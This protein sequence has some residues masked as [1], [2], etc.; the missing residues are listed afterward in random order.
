MPELY[1]SRIITHEKH[2]TNA[3]MG[4]D[5]IIGMDLMSELGIDILNSTHSIKWDDAEIP[6]RHRTVTINDAYH[7]SDP[8]LVKEATSKLTTILDAKYEAANLKEVYKST[9]N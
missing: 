7:I 9:Q 3:Y 2:V 6:M 5:M 1:Q 4:Y 8:I